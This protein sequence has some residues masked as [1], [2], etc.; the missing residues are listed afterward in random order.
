[1]CVRLRLAIGI[2]FVSFLVPQGSFAAALRIRLLRP[3]HA[4][5]LVRELTARTA[6]ELVATGFSVELQDL[7]SVDGLISEAPEGAPV[8][9]AILIDATDEEALRGSP[10][11]LIETTLGG[12]V[13]YHATVGL[14]Q[15][16]GEE[17]ARVLSAAAVRAVASLQAALTD[18]PALATPD[19]ASTAPAVAVPI[20][21][22]KSP[23]RPRFGLGVA[24]SMSQSLAGI[25][26]IF[27]P[28]VRLSYRFTSLATSLVAVGLRLS[29]LGTQ[30]TATSSAGSAQVGQDLAMADVLLGWRPSK[31]L[32]P[33]VV[34][35]FGL[36]HMT[37]DGTGASPYVGRTDSLWAAAA[38]VGA[39]L[40]V[41]ITP[42][43]SAVLEIQTLWV[44]PEPAVMIDVV[45]A[46]RIG[47]PCFVNS[48][49]LVVSL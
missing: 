45:N 49:G 26:P 19:I 10:S 27:A 1:M 14:G 32:H 46:G 8:V 44:W 16:G 7:Q 4:S 24:G 12:R 5:A 23:R 40:S 28:V 22:D 37:I 21:A 25:R 48:L 3:A 18:R 42:R 39:G 38:S 36:Y 34:G 43:L 31:R 33:M 30:A 11:A 13:I 15:I 41:D 17:R 2:A 47:R 6:G 29:T 35:G 9:A 20:A